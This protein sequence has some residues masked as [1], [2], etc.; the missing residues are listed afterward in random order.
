M[1][2]R[3][4]SDVADA[5]SEGTRDRRTLERGFT[6]EGGGQW[7]VRCSVPGAVGMTSVENMLIKA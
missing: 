5:M 2:H 3:K 6:V 4:Y 7:S 1:Q